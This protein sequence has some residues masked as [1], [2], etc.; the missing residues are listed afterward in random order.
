[1]RAVQYEKYGGA[2]V[3]NLIDAPEPEAGPKQVLIEIHSTAVNPIDWKLRSGSM[4]RLYS[5]SL[6]VIVGFDVSGVVAAVGS[7]VRNFRVGDEVFARSNKKA[8][9]ASAE[10]IALDEDVVAR[11]PAKL[12]HDEAAAVPLAGLTALQALRDLAGL[13]P[14]QRVL[15]NGASGGVGMYAVQIARAMFDAEV[16]ATC[17]AANVDFVKSLGAGDIIDYRAGDPLQTDEKYDCIFDVVMSLN[18]SR[19][20]KVLNPGG[21][22]VATS[23]SANL[24]YSLALGNL[25]SSRKA[26]LILVKSNGSDLAL[27]GDLADDGRLRSTIDS[28]YSLEEIQKAHERSESGRARGKIVIQVKQV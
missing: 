18:F 4:K 24:L 11:K 14:G 23:L 7:E 25:F 19:A 26:R 17:S 9:E 12:S 8:G 10:W 3:L 5:L 16:V 28:T 27:L 6:P 1:M 20:R 15:I 13:K 2:D 21:T 22:I